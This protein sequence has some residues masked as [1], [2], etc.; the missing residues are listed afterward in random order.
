MKYKRHIYA[1]DFI[2]IVVTIF[3]L[4]GLIGYFGYSQPLVIAPIDE[5]ETT[6]TSVLFSFEK[7]DLI[8]IDEN[9]DFTSPTKI[10]VEDNLVI[11]LKPGVYYWKV[12][13]DLES[14]VRK[15]TI[16]SEIDL[17]LK[18][19][20]GEDRYDI[21]N[22]GNVELDVDVF[23]NG[24]LRDNIRLEIDEEKEISGTKFIGRENA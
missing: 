13:G 18:K 3:S 22:A 8:L 10:Y 24:V 11:N 7:A 14:D 4:V 15:L 2:L 1:V 19:V 17:K 21:V 5:Y 20:D 16:I 23:E 6:E 9:P 12:K